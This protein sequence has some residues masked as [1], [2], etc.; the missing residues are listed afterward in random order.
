MRLPVN[1]SDD[2][3]SAHTTIS[4]ESSWRQ[5]VAT[6]E[7][8]VQT[9]PLEMSHQRTQHPKTRETEVQSEDVSEV[10]A[11]PMLRSGFQKLREL[12]AFLEECTPLLE[13]QLH[14]NLTSR[15]FD[16]HD[17]SW[18]EQH[19]EVTCL[20]SLKH[21]GALASLS[22][23]ACTAVAWNA[24]GTVVAAAYG[25]LDRNDWPR[26]PSMLCTWSIFRRQLDP[27]K[28]D[29]AIE[30][31]DC[32]TCLAFH[33]EDPSL[34][35]GGSYSGEVL[36]WRIG[37]RGDPL[38]GK[39]VLTDF[40]HHEPIHQLAWTLNPQAQARGGAGGAS[41]VSGGGKGDKAGDKYVLASV[42]ADGKMLMW[43]PANKLA[44]PVGG[45]LLSS[46]LFRAADRD[47]DGQIT[48]EEVL[49]AQ[50][51]A[52][53]AELESGASVSFS[54]EDPTTFVVGLEAGHLYKGSLLA[55]ELRSARAITREPA[56]L[57]WSVPAASLLCRVPQAQYHKLKTRVEKEALLAR[58]RPREVLTT[59]VFDAKPSPR[60]LYASPLTFS[61]DGCSGPV[62]AARFSPFHRNVFLA[63]STDASLRLYNQLTPA[64]FHVTEP[65]AAPLLAAAWSPS[66]PLVFAAASA[67]GSLYIYDLKRSKAKAE[68]TLQVT[69]SSKRAVTAV[70]FNPKSAE[71]VATADADGFIKIWRL[72]T[73][74]S[75]AAPREAEALDAMAS[76]GRG[77]GGG[78]DDDDDDDA[79]AAYAADAYE[80]D[81]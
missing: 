60:E 51:A 47:G 20:H 17:V 28:A 74:L 77:G 40:T 52:A 76:A 35:A 46:S 9:D 23:D 75:E 22:P 29:T 27:S 80:D 37:G 30:L 65:S 8:G 15:A 64:P 81:A 45:F 57:P 7:S 32:L 72:S 56:E 42:G 78:A 4:F 13:Q 18:E 34:L 26:C 48:R 49:A 5:N 55:N 1:L 71:L 21:T 31:P 6:D 16:G 61:F 79:G 2:D 66:R 19:D 69:S 36:L 33:P 14:R 63:A 58:D 41:G 67:D 54:S 24:S 43:S 59:H 50:H 70:A 73:F 25:P 44:T 12:D 38:V 68:V 11:V 10:G 3:A 62:Y 53:T 39:S